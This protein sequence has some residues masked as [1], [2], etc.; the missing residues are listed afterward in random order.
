MW[1]TGLIR[2][3]SP[4]IPPFVINLSNF[5]DYKTLNADYY[6]APF[7]SASNSYKMQLN[8]V[9]NGHSKYKGTHL[10]VFVYLMKGINDE[11]LKWP[12]TAEISIHLL[13]WRQNKGHVKDIIPYNDNT[14]L[15]CRSRV[16]KG[17]R[18]P[19][20]FGHFDFI[21]HDELGYNTKSNTEYLSSNT[22]CFV[23]NN[24]SR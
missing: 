5:T 6:S 1:Y 10:T 17:E 15:E 14:P 2:K 21:S 18:T 16:V 19:D 22:L 23:I 13:N 7:Y 20:G 11:T 12:F 3:S 24:V 8:V 4:S 9:A